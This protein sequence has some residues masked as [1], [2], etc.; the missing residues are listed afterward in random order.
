MMDDNEWASLFKYGE[1]DT[2]MSQWAK[3]AEKYMPGRR[4]VFQSMDGDMLLYALA[5][6]NRNVTILKKMKMDIAFQKHATVAPS[7]EPVRDSDFDSDD[8]ESAPQ[9]A[10]S[11][12]S[13]ISMADDNR[14]A[15][16]A[17]SRISMADDNR[18][19]SSAASSAA[20][21]ADNGAPGVWRDADRLVNVPLPKD[22]AARI[23]ERNG[24]LRKMGYKVQTGIQVVH[25]N[26]LY[27]AIAGADPDHSIVHTFIMLVCTTGTDYSKPVKLVSI[28]ATMRMAMKTVEFLQSYQQSPNIVF[29]GDLQAN[30][31]KDQSEDPPRNTKRKRK[32]NKAPDAE[33][34]VVFTSDD[35]GD[36]TDDEYTLGSK[37]QRVFECRGQNYKRKFK[38][39][40]RPP[41]AFPY[42]V[43][44]ETTRHFIVNIKGILSSLCS[45]TLPSFSAAAKSKHKHSADFVNV[46]LLNSIYSALYFI[47]LSEDLDYPDHTLLGFEADGHRLDSTD[48]WHS[49]KEENADGFT[50]MFLKRKQTFS[51]AKK[52]LYIPY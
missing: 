9:T 50:T 12:A 39:A 42:V 21:S 52:R 37:K 32:R 26:T 44:D 51:I 10:S 28:P 16:S 6:K 46:A 47:Y 19:A 17:A 14:S 36:D 7:S 5:F 34:D 31:I 1:A 8:D 20:V 49:A 3:I 48:G 22:R 29:L 43:K 24:I 38:Y 41:S 11:A 13:R 27:D 15:S 30:K 40:I 23:K 18:S 25:I 4:V 2:R 45:A 33:E 35:D